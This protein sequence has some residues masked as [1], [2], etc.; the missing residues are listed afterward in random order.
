[1]AHQ[2]HQKDRDCKVD[3]KGMTC[4]LSWETE[5]KEDMEDKGCY[6]VLENCLRERKEDIL[7]SDQ[8][9]GMKTAEQEA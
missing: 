1:M 2:I 5:G 3:M 9:L 6:L 7:Q 4:W 8:A